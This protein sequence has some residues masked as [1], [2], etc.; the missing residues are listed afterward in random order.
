MKI[1]FVGDASNMHNCLAQ[2]L[3]D[4]GHTAIVASSGSHWMNTSRDINLKRGPGKLGAIRYVLDVMRALPQMRGFDVV[5]TCGHIFLDLK[6]GKV[7]RVF[8]WLK[9]HNR[10]IV[11]SAL[12]T[13][14][15]YYQT[16]HDGKTYRYS[17]Y[18][19]GD[20]PSPFALSSEYQ[21]KNEDNWKLPIMREHSEHILNNID[22]AISALWEY[23]ACYKPLL[24]DRLTYGGIPIDTKTV[25]PH[26]IDSEPEKVK[27]FI[28]IQRDRNILKGTDL[29]LKAAQRTVDRYPDLC[30][31]KVVESVPYEEY[32]KFLNQS[33][34]L[35]D[36]LYSYTPATNALL[37]MARGLVA[38]SGAEPEYYELIGEHENQPIINVSPLIEGDIDAKLEWIVQNKHLLPDL[39]RRSREFV[40]KHNEAHVVAQ[41]HLKFYET[42]LNEKAQTG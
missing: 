27:F 6:P 12:G 21:S 28:G 13:D 24:G 10:C 2:A 11:M 31:L 33:H 18:M 36:Q 32:V 16:C 25:E 42:I 7:R 26:I 19:A 22:G 17:D 15:I 30:E 1:L 14:Y 34:V 8:D 39:S 3:R 35:L 9:R 20:H 40:E 23:H 37:A 29:L 41:R 5:V 38:V 4:L